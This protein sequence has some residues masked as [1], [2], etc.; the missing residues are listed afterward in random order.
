MP[1]TYS[2]THFDG[3]SLTAT[4]FKRGWFMSPNSPV[5]TRPFTPVEPTPYHGTS[6]C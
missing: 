1:H 3:V 2:P 5:Q 6:V 4:P